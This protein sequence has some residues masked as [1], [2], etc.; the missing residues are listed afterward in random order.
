MLSYKPDSGIRVARFSP[1]Q[2]VVKVKNAS[3][4]T[5]VYL[6]NRYKYWQATVDGEQQL[7]QTAYHTFMA[8]A[9]AP[10]S[11]IVV[12]AYADMWFFILCAV[13]AVSFAVAFGLFLVARN[14]IKITADRL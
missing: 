14:R 4:D 1:T 12:F 10:G 7:I 11:H 2:I 8:V 13:A 9:L 3:T 6:Q 5:L